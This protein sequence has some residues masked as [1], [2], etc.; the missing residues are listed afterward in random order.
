[1]GVCL[2]LV[3][4]LGVCFAL[5]RYH[6]IQLPGDVYYITNLPV[7]IELLDVCLIALSAV[8]ICFL[9]TI[10]PAHRASKRNPVEALRYG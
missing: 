2:G 9:A 4:G 10:Y 7:Q 3:L 1:M 8:F 6:F 5:D